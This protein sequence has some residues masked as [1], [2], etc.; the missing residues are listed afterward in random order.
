MELLIIL[1]LIGA[2]IYQLFRMNIRNGAET[3]RAYMFLHMLQNGASTEQA[4]AVT[5]GVDV[6]EVNQ[7]IIRD[8][9]AFVRETQDGKQIP[10]IRTAYAK[11]MASRLPGWYRSIM[12]L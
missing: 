9:M 6:S 10:L 7:D 2:G 11:G 12:Q 5:G 4:R 1:L 8:A 3:V